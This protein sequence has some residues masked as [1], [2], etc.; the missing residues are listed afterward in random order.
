MPVVKAR[1]AAENEAV[2]GVM[3]V[4]V[5]GHELTRD[6]AEIEVSDAV[7]AKLKGNPCIEALVRKPAEPVKPATPPQPSAP[8]APSV[9]PV[10][11]AETQ[12]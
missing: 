6:Y 8:Q 11:P 2:A 9:T 7:L 12:G 4:T 1:I 5:F 10:S 3:S